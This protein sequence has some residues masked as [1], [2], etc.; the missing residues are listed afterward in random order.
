MFDDK[1]QVGQITYK[2]NATCHN[3]VVIEIYKSSVLFE[4]IGYCHCA[5]CII[6]HRIARL[7]MVGCGVT[8]VTILSLPEYLGPTV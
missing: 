8:L 3:I 1:R 6:T 7:G 2:A 4:V 5:L